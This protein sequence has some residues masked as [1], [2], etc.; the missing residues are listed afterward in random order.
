[1]AVQQVTLY[2]LDRARAEETLPELARELSATVGVPDDAG[3]VELEVEAESH[4][5]ALARVR[6]AIA[7]TGAEER[8]TFPETTGTG[9]H[10]PGHRAPPPDEEPDER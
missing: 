3:M 2:A 7:A 10:P 5:D 9:F 8:F 4:E 1:V 6:D